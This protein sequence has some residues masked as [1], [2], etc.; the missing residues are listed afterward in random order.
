[1]TARMW[2]ASASLARPQDEGIARALRRGRERSQRRRGP[3]QPLGALR[4]G[5]LGR[6]TG[7]GEQV[8][9][10]SNGGSAAGYLATAKEGAGPGVV[11]VQE[12][13]G[14]DSYITGV[15]DELSQEGF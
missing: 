1:M 5:P 10:A 11:V 2:R 12:W 6:V 3:S 7:M 14:L 13:W 15:A 9:F 4:D 8:E